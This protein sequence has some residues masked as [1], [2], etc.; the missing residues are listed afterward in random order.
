M[1]IKKVFVKKRFFKKYQTKKRLLAVFLV[2]VNFYIWA[3]VVNSLP[4]IDFAV[5]WS[6]ERI[7]IE[8]TNKGQFLK[9]SEVVAVRELSVEDKIKAVFGDEWKIA[10]AVMMAESNGDP[11]RIGDK[12]LSK[13]SVGLFQINQIWHPYSTEHLQNPDNNIKIAKEIRDKGSWD[14]WTTYRT[15]RYLAFMN[16]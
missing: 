16:K 5:G 8:N 9:P 4:V 14:R 10:Y 15:G 3:N 7:V 11:T 6:D 2:I 12:H 13:P 1:K